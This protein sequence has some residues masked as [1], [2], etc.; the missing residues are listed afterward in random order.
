MRLDGSYSL[1]LRIININFNTNDSNEKV[2]Y[3]NEV[4]LPMCDYGAESDDS[5]SLSETFSNDYIFSGDSED[6]IN[7]SGTDDSDCHID[8]SNERSVQDLKQWSFEFGVNRLCL[9]KLLKLLNTR[10]PELL[11]CA[12]TFQKLIGPSLYKIIAF[13]EYSEFV[14]FGISDQLKKL[15]NPSLHLDNILKLQFNVNG[16]PLYQSSSKE[17]WPILGKIL[18]NLIYT[19]LS[20]LLFIDK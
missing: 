6:D 19:N 11:L 8:Q 13:D 10:I 4:I 1:N 16:L 15:I 9:D 3:E 2:L 12:K 5:S 20:R 7:D 14:Y 17:F 18:L